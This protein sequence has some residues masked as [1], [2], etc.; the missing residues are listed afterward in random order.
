MDLVFVDEIDGVSINR[1][2]PGIAEYQASITTAFLT[3][4]N[5]INNSDKDIVFIGV[6]NFPERMDSAMHSRVELIRVPLPDREARK[7]YFEH[8]I[9]GR[10]PGA[11]GRCWKN[12]Q[13]KDLFTWVCV[14]WISA[15]RRTDMKYRK[16][17][18]MK[19]SGLY[20]AA[21]EEQFYE[22]KNM[23]FSNIYDAV[24]ER[25]PLPLLSSLPI[26]LKKE[27]G[28]EVMWFYLG[29]QGD[30]KGGVIQINDI[31]TAKDS[32]VTL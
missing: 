19:K 26:I 17:C 28:L 15:L 1:N 8:V 32:E 6:T 30:E 25:R 3:D 20:M 16:I 18:L 2:L 7:G 29:Y 11:A 9:T 5:H 23:N 21:T 4:Y 31:C 24:E 13:L 22:D 27:D 12:R 14:M 10:R